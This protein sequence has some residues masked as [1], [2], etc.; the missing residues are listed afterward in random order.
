[1][2]RRLWNQFG[3]GNLCYTAELGPVLSWTTRVQEQL[4]LNHTIQ[5][6]KNQNSSPLIRETS[7]IQQ[8]LD[9]RSVEREL[10]FPSLADLKLLAL[11]SPR[12]RAAPACW[13]A[14]G[15]P[16][17]RL[18]RNCPDQSRSM[19]HVASGEL[20]KA[21]CFH[22]KLHFQSINLSQWR[23]VPSENVGPV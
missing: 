10:G 12:Q 13:Q 23:N 3:H 14:A 15:E 6:L 17:R 7:C 8:L 4:E 21:R 18:I 19:F 1:M 11:G 9:G 22:K 2:R 20:L 5:M 16:A